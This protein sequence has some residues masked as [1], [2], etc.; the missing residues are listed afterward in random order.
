[1]KDGVY[2]CQFVV[3]QVQFLNIVE[4]FQHADILDLVLPEVESVDHIFVYHIC[5]EIEVV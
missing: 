1:M 2:I 3:F 5:Q 4:F